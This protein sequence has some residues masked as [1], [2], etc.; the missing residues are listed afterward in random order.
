MKTWTKWLLTAAIAGCFAF[1]ARS[2]SFA[3]GE[4]DGDKKED[5]KSDKER[6]HD[7]RKKEEMAKHHEERMRRLKERLHKLR[8][9]MDDKC[10]ARLRE[11]FAKLDKDNDG[12]LGRG[13]RWEAF[14]K[15]LQEH[16]EELA[17]KFP[18][19]VDES[20]DLDGDGKVSEEEASDFME[21]MREMIAER[22]EH[23]EKKRESDK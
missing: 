17:D 10:C 18:E 5:G 16:R 8:E 22:K 2:M 9:H 15:W 20:A 21:H 4:R 13:E 23:D 6:E 11:L 7:R 14:K 12:K 3:D 19:M 1:G